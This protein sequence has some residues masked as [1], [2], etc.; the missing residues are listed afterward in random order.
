MVL[1]NSF[2]LILNVFISGPAPFPHQPHQ[3]PVASP[4]L[5]QPFN[6]SYPQQSIPTPPVQV[7]Q[8][9]LQQ[10]FPD[11]QPS[12]SMPRNAPRPRPQHTGPLVPPPGAKSD[13][14][15]LRSYK[16]VDTAT[17]ADVEIDYGSFL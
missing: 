13:P 12:Y 4:P 2:Q 15:S 8:Q 3:Q 17:A 7:H 16:D 11:R 10:P 6:M 14:R 5:P 9:Q 1:V